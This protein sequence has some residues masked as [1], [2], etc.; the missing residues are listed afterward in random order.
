[1]EVDRSWNI[2]GLIATVIGMAVLLGIWDLA[3][4]L[5]W[6]SKPSKYDLPILTAA[7]VVLWVFWHFEDERKSQEKRIKEIESRLDAL[8]RQ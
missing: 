4:F 8:E 7:I 5:L 6:G 3:D 2:P 1:M